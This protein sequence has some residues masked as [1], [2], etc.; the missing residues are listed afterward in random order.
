MMDQRQII[1]IL[2]DIAVLIIVA[3]CAYYWGRNAAESAC[4]AQIKDIEIKQKEAQ[5]EL[6]VSA[7]DS[8]R[9][10]EV[11]GAVLTTKIERAIDEVKTQPAAT[12]KPGAA[13]LQL[14]QRAYSDTNSAIA[15]SGTQ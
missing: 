5:Q 12:C 13:R 10:A 6:A 3:A 15:G 8:E 9:K 11:A 2:V 14:L 1:K 4:E 7:S